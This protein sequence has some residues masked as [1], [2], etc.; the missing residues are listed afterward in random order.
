MPESPRPPLPPRLDELNVG[1]LN[2]LFRRHD[3]DFDAEVVAVRATPIGES[4]GFLGQLRRLELTYATTESNRHAPSGT[5]PPASL[6][7]KAPTQDPGGR[8]VG[9]MLDVWARESRFF[10][11]LASALDVH[12]PRCYANEGDRDTQQW[13]LLLEDVGDTQAPTQAEG[14]S[15]DQAA[16]ALIEVA[17][18]HRQC[19]GQRPAPWL[20][21]FDRGPLDALQ[22]NVQVAV[23]PFAERF[24]DLLPPGGA[25]ALRRF[26]PGLAAWTNE[27]ARHPLT[28][29]HADYRLDNL[30]VRSE[31]AGLTVTVLDWQTTLMGAGEMDL[32]S[33]LVTSLRLEDRRRWED[34]LIELYAEAVGRSV[35][36]VRAAFRSHLW[37]WMAL[38]ANNLSRIDPTDER[39]TN[40]FSATVQRTFQ[41]AA[42]HD[43]LNSDRQAG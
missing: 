8:Q 5:T 29:V 34:G 40:M 33:F 31:G 14:A 23:E 37:W 16:A 3:P 11:E 10:A 41:A 30:I 1:V 38:Y 19:H 6:V 21:G 43:L 42:D 22:H 7:A 28:V 12:V 35:D 13:L 25:D 2:A 4:S 27:Q 26:A 15:F 32:A 17:R 39:G 9:A 24:G 36:Q 18:L 20:P